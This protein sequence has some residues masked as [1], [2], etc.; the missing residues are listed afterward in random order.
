MCLLF[1][2]VVHHKSNIIKSTR[3]KRSFNLL[4]FFSACCKPE[5]KVSVGDLLDFVIVKRFQEN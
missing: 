3:E 1:A 5:K 2:S 4:D